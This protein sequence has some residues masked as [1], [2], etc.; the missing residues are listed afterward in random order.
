MK[1]RFSRRAF[2]SD[3]KSRSGAAIVEFA[4]VC[5]I[6]FL[7]VFGMVD[8]G[9]GL[10]VQNLLTNAARDGARTAALDGATASDVEAAVAQYLSSMSVD[11]A[12]VT[13]TPNPLSTAGLGDPVSV[14]VTVPFNSVSWLPSSMYFAGV[15]LESTVVMRREV[16]IDPPV[17]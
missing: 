10:M 13:V 4:I 9:R 11:G 15:N 3:K 6:L 12:S 5:P 1:T 2:Q 17:E 14:T 8:V 16:Y 7:I